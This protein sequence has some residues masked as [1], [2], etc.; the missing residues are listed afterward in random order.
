MK[1]NNLWFLYTLLATLA[2]G[3]WG[4]FINL[5]AEAGFPETLG[6]AVWALTMI[7][8]AAVV[9]QR[10]GWRIDHDKR[11]IYLGCLAGLLGAGG[12]LILFKTLRIAPAYLVFPFIALS[13][14][15]TI[16]L[17]LVISR[18]R[19]GLKGWL[20]I[21]L[22]LVAG[23][24]LSYSSPEGDGTS[25]FLWV[26]P[27]LLVFL[28]WGLQGF[29]IS[30]ANKTM[31]VESIF[32]YMALTSLLLIPVALAMTDFSQP[33]TWG[34]KGPYLAALIQLLNSVGALV[35]VFAFRYGKA[36]IVAPLINAGA[37]VITIVVSLLMYRTLPTPIGAIGM[38]AAILA[39]VLM[40]LDE[41]KA[42][43]TPEAGAEG[44]GIAPG[45]T[46]PVPKSSSTEPSA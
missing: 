3:L 8:P 21:V 12:Q 42:V 46:G 5:T 44:V 20:G 27:A 10:S 1:S 2:W 9:L 4:A 18:E 30:H 15:V 14:L 7:L 11:S 16:V 45:A 25:G 19:A 28:A 38:V 43:S 17:A 40:A 41:S 39:T 35:L 23:V 31:T 13:P 32:F 26:I 36:I 24:L 33:I 6:Y 37:P 34:F 22:A 29:A